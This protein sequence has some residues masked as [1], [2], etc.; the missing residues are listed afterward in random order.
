MLIGKL[1]KATDTK[2]NT[3]RFYEGIGLMP[4]PARTES[5]QRVYQNGDVR[6]LAFIRHARALG[7]P[8]DEVRSLLT[9][10]EA[11][12]NECS[13][14]ADIA[15]HHLADI[16]KRI[17]QLSRLRNELTDILESCS[18]GSISDCSVINGIARR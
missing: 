7:F 5:G 3:I 17:S 4:V 10:R 6:R 9:L 13:I 2:V 16:E 11:P 15:A 12:E 14:A 1:A 18:G 8:T